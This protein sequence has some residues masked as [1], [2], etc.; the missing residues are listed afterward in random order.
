ML[1]VNVI[2]VALKCDPFLLNFCYRLFD[3]NFNF[4]LYWLKIDIFYK[5]IFQLSNVMI[6]ATIHI[7]KADRTSLPSKL[8][9]VG[10]GKT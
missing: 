9:G 6:Q 8:A 3:K 2:Y 1:T 7:T 4:L 5:I 10:P